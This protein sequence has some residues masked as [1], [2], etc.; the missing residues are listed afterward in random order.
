MSKKLILVNKLNEDEIFHFIV[1]NY[2]IL[3]RKWINHQ[4]NWMG[5]SF[6]F[7]KDHAKSLVLEVILKEILKSYSQNK[8]FYQFDEFFN[9]SNL[10]IDKFTIGKISE[11]LDSP[12]E[13]IRRKLIELEKKEQISIKNKQ[14]ITKKSLLQKSITDQKIKLLINYLEYFSNLLYEKKL[15]PRNF[16]SNEIEKTIKNNFSH[17]WPWYCEMQISMMTSWKK[18]FGDFVSFHIWST[19]LINQLHHVNKKDFMNSGDIDRETL[20]KFMI[21]ENLGHGVNSFSLSEILNIPRTTIMRKCKEMI[22]SKK[23]KY[24]ERKQFILHGTNVAKFNSVQEKILRIKAKFLS[25]LLNFQLA[26]IND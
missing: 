24:N 1:K 14:I 4:W 9:N 2:K 26:N 12:K 18:H 13:T 8:I 21:T 15:I 23:L 25:K 7:F 22:E 10:I 11:N 5:L 16:N 6:S 17:I 3:S 19:C 20:H